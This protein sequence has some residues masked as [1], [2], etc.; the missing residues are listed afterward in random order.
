MKGEGIRKTRP[1]EKASPDVYI[2]ATPCDF[3]TH[4]YFKG[5][6]RTPQAGG[7]LWSSPKRGFQS[8]PGGD[9]A[10][11]KTSLQDHLE[12][13]SCTGTEA[14]SSA[15][16]RTEVKTHSLIQKAAMGVPWWL[17]GLR[18]WRCHSCG[19]S[20]LP[21]PGAS[22]CPWHGQ[23]KKKSREHL[24]HASLALDAKN[25]GILQKYKVG[26]GHAL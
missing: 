13:Q 16:Q 8:W 18:I 14:T 12:R 2:E 26:K 1:Q 20:L 24:I 5:R 15:S 3:V 10:Q 22:E 11:T 25:T 19:R 7:G 17:S 9:K 23:K 21:D 4:S 6:R